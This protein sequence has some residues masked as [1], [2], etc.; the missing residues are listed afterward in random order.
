MR[1]VLYAMSFSLRSLISG[2]SRDNCSLSSGV[3]WSTSSVPISAS[4]MAMLDLS[5]SIC[6]L[7]SSSDFSWKQVKKFSMHSIGNIYLALKTAKK[8][9]KERNILKNE[10]LFSRALRIACFCLFALAISCFSCSTCSLL[11]VQSASSLC[12]SVT[13]CVICWSISETS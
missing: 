11:C 2:F 7:I 1:S 5:C 13:S 12:C 8:L 9:I 10:T 6:V 4:F 3:R